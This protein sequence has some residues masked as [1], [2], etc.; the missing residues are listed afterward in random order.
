MFIGRRSDGSIYGSWACPQP[1]D[2]DHPNI[3]EVKDD[4][5]ELV[6][7]LNRSRPIPVNPQDVK[8]EAL[9]SR[10]AAI[11]NSRKEENGAVPII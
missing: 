4:E 8:I 7:F 5:P 6:A 3:E 2:A 11:E 1:M 9:E 10:L